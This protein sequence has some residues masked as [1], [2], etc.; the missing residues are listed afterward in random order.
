MDL[1]DIFQLKKFNLCWGYNTLAEILRL[2][3]GDKSQIIDHAKPH[4]RKQVLPTQS[5]IDQCI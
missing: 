2:M 3:A 1:I 4:K 5:G